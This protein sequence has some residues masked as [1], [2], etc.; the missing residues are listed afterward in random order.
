MMGD[1]ALNVRKANSTAAA[2]PEEALRQVEGRARVRAYERFNVQ[3]RLQH[4]VLF[5]SFTLLAVTGLP[6]KYAE[7]AWASRVAA[8]FGGMDAMLYIHLF[9]ASMMI[10][11]AVNHLLYLLFGVIVGEF[12]TAM[13]PTPKDFKDLFDN[14]RYQLGLTDQ[15]PKFGRYSYKE[16]FDYWAVFWGMFIMVGSG[17]VLWFPSIAVKYIPLWAIEAARVA[18][19]DEAILAVAAIFI[20]HMYNVHFR[21]RVFPMSLVWWTGTMTEEEM[22]KEHP[23]ELRQRKL[24]EGADGVPAY[25][26]RG[27]GEESPQAKV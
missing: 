16:K 21:P 23:V 19:S 8:L 2:F 17:L 9:G 4:I 27:S 13:F 14:I 6:I 10:A 24:Q 12:S 18:H 11:V 22:E 7:T 5:I 26:E 1:K 25:P 20:W 3:Q 15:E